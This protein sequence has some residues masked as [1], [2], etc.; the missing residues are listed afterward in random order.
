MN[1]LQLVVTSNEAIGSKNSRKA[2]MGSELP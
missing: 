1:N 2:S